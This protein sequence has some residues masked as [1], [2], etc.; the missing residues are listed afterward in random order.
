[1]LICR[2]FSILKNCKYI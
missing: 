2:C 1:M